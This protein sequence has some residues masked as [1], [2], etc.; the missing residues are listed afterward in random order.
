MTVNGKQQPRFEVANRKYRFRVLNGS[1][2]RQYALAVRRVANVRRAVEDPGANEPF[3]LIGTDQGLLPAPETT[4]MVHTMP[5]NRQ[6]LVIDF[7]RY[8]IGTRL[9]LVN[10]LVDPA[11]PK[12][13]Q[14]MAFDVRRTAP[15]PSRIPPRLRGPEHPADTQPPVRTR[16]WRFDRQNG[17]WSIN[18][19]QWDPARVDAFPTLDTNE[20][21]ILTNESGGWGHPVHIHLGRFRV[22]SVQGRPPRPGELAG[23]HD[24]AWVGPNQTIR[25]VHQ[26]WNFPGRFVFHCHNGSHEDHDMMSQF[27]VRP[28]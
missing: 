26:F 9:V 20:E 27:E 28:A 7:S 21:W 5:A 14:L 17:Q 10:L 8:P 23:F 4:D 1:D 3:T 15:D 19:R 12:L 6:E 22:R 18:G 24:V 16:A 25:V 13:F 2:K 11:K